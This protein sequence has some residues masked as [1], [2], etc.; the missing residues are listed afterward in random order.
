MRLKMSKKELNQGMA[1]LVIKNGN[2]LTMDAARPQAEAL[3]VQ[4]DRIIA[5]PAAVLPM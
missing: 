1:D 3:A 2:I 4:G 5:K